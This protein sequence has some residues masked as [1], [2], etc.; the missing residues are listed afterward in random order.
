MTTIIIFI[1]VFRRGKPLYL[2]KDR[3]QLLEQQ[4]LAHRFDHTK[5]T[6]VWHRDAL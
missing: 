3:Y 4:W 5:K 6:W 2:S 1:Y